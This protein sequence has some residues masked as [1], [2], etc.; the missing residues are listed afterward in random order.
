MTRGVAAACLAACAACA[1]ATHPRELVGVSALPQEAIAPEPA[2]PPP[3]D[4]PIVRQALLRMAAL[5]DLPA[6]RPVK[7]VTL[8]RAELVTKLRAHVAAV[9]PERAIAGEAQF[10]KLLGAIRGWV[11]YERATFSLVGDEIAGFYEPEDETLYLPAD[12]DARSG[13]AALVHE[14]V[15]ALQDQHFDLKRRERYVDGESDALLAQSCLAEGDATSAMADFMMQDEGKTALD[16]P[17]AALSHL[18]DE[19]GP[20]PPYVQRSVFAPYTEGLRFVNALRRRGGW[21]EV[22]RAWTRPVLTTEQVLHPEKWESGEAAIEVAAPTFTAL[23]GGWGSVEVDRKGELGARLVFESW[24][25]PEQAARAAE[26][27]GGDRVA[28]AKDGS[29]A[30]LAW[31]LRYDDAPAPDADAHARDAFAILARAALG[32]TAA[33]TFACAAR[34]SGATALAR[35]QR[36]VLVLVAPEDCAALERWAA[37][38]LGN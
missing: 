12:L 23:G 36:D 24:T 28:L 4:D 5:R 27:W 13:A 19:S 15:H 30:A 29:R 10:A 6:L 8:P 38:V 9:Y 14:V 17:D 26:H 20:V 18:V 3:A 35:K 34:A 32:T 33:K 7:G 16:A 31:R 25:T 21:D 22:D 37:A 11:D 1:T 2:R